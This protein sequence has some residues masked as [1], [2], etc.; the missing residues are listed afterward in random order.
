MIV[1]LSKAKGLAVKTGILPLNRV[2]GRNAA[3]D[4]LEEAA[5]ERP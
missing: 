5:T 2:R 1:I 4:T 3:P